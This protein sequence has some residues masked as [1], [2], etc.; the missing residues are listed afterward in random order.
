MTDTK[1]K[2]LSRVG[3]QSQVKDG[4]KNN[5]LKELGS[6]LTLSSKCSSDVLLMFCL[7]NSLHPALKGQV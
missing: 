4:T 5:I 7:K 1:N 3:L 2:Y 6:E